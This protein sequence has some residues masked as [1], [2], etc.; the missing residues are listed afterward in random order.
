VHA[1]K[2]LSPLRN[3]S[4]P[5]SSGLINLT[6]FQ[7]NKAFEKMMEAP[8]WQTIDADKSDDKLCDELQRLL[9]GKLQSTDEKI[10][11]LW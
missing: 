11:T 1:I 4:C 6:Y 9:L 5:V 3:T 7:V 8:L 10:Q 2:T